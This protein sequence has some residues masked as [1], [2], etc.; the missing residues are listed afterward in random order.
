V[1]T[2][3]NYAILGW[4][5]K[6]KDP[7]LWSL[8]AEE[9][10]YVGFAVLYLAG[11]Y[12][13]KWLVWSLTVC[14]VIGSE[15]VFKRDPDY[16]SLLRS[17]VLPAAFLIGNLFYLHIETLKKKTV[18]TWSLFTVAFVACLATP[19]RPINAL[20]QCVAILILGSVV[21]WPFKRMPFDMSYGIYVYH[22][23]IAFYLQAH[24]VGEWWPA[25]IVSLLVAAGSWWG[26]ERFAIGLKNWTP[27]WKTAADE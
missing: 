4:F 6:G 7:A 17:T 15:L 3:H 12:R 14:A 27:H 2:L 20:L 11:A 23:P 19:D 1:E 18:L 10:I 16:D 22:F 26:V 8:E 24:G 25:A 5:N 21:S 9:I 13:I